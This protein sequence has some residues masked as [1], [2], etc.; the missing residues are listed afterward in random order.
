MWWMWLHNYK[1]WYHKLQK[2]WISLLPTWVLWLL[3]SLRYPIYLSPNA[4]VSNDV[5]NK[6]QI[7]LSGW[8]I[9][10]LFLRQLSMLLPYWAV[11]K[12]GRQQLWKKVVQCNTITNDL[13]TL[14]CSQLQFPQNCEV[15]WSNC[16]KSSPARKL[17]I[18]GHYS[19]SNY[20]CCSKGL[21]HVYKWCDVRWF[22]IAVV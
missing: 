21:R 4:P 13:C 2:W 9:C 18:A 22:I 10:N 16:F 17:Y 5:G 8:N 14:S 19:K 1:L 15:I 12:R 20:T 6:S 3:S 7:I 11:S